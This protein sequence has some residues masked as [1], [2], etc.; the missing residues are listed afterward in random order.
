MHSPPLVDVA[1]VA[2]LPERYAP[3]WNTLEYCRHVG[4]EKQAGRPLYWMARVRCANGKYRQKRLGM[5][6]ANGA[7]E[8]EFQTAVEKA[9]EWFAEGTLP[10]IQGFTMCWK[11]ILR[12][13]RRVYG[14][15]PLKWSTNRD[16]LIPIS[17]GL[18]DG[19]EARQARRH[20]SEAAAG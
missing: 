14:V 10:G 18:R 7:C 5:V 3:Y 19:W 2:A 17:G 12:S 15:P 4:I 20:R 8:G 11:Q 6:S 1:T 9:R 16:M 13:C